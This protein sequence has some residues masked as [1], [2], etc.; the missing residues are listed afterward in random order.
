MLAE[1]EDL[2]TNPLCVVESVAAEKRGVRRSL[3]LKWGRL[4]IVPDVSASGARAGRGAPR[5]AA[6]PYHRA[7]PASAPR[8]AVCLV[9][10]TKPDAGYPIDGIRLRV[11]GF[12]F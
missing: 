6:L 7:H 3:L 11:G 4:V 12:G 1:G 10:R 9:A 8:W 5:S 2:P